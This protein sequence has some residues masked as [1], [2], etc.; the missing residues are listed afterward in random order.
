[1]SLIFI[2]ERF[3]VV[4]TI[5]Q[6]CNQSFIP[7][8]CASQSVG[9]ANQLFVS[10]VQTLLTAQ[11][12]ISPS[13]MWPEDYGPIA[14]KRGLD[15]YDFIVIGAGSA[16]ATVAS[17]LSEISDWKILLLEAGGDPPLEA[18]VPAMTFTLQNTRVDWKFRST[19]RKA[20][21]GLKDGCAFPRGKVLGGSSTINSMEY[22]RGIP[23]DFNHWADLGNTGWDFER[24]LPYFKKSENQQQPSLVA[25]QGGRYHSDKGPMKV[26][27]LGQI[28]DIESL[29]IAAANE[30]GIPF[31]PDINADQHY[32]CI[33]MQGTY[34]QGRRWSTAKAFLIPAKNRTNLHIIKHAFVEKILID[35]N[36]RAYGVRFSI[37]KCRKCKCRHKLTARAR[38]EVILSAGVVMSPILLK[39]SGIGPA[40]ELKNHNIPVKANLFGVGRNFLD[41]LYCF[42]LFKF[43]PVP[44]KP[45]DSL[46]YYY[47]FLTQN[48]G[49]YAQPTQL[50]AFLST[51]NNKTHPDIE[52]Y[53]YFFPPN[54][55]DFAF[56]IEL[57]NFLPEIKQRM[58][59][60]NK[61][62]SIAA[63]IPVLL[64]P[65]SSGFINLNGTCIRNKPAIYPH[66]LEHKDD[67]DRLVIAVKQ[68][69]EFTKTNAYQSFGGSFLP[70][71]IP[72]CDKL[73][74]SSDEFWRCYISYMSM[75]D[76]H[77]I[78]TCKMGPSTDRM[79]VVDPRLKVYKTLG[80]R[81]IDASM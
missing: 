47:Q 51:T 68:Q 77:G 9:A 36:N 44:T 49:P 79:A 21:R 13:N 75:S 60:T 42:L 5:M 2:D 48:S 55:P 35:R 18:D 67:L 34:A 14:L 12:S 41:H 23:D 66:Y 54:S 15:L 11:C 56:L 3:D 1:M 17:R 33:N 73:T 63:A 70:M 74:Y 71:P 8:D 24:V 59:D 78:G 57:M 80:L 61:E 16:G 28:G 46:D 62:F 27:Y 72:E 7:P 10:L 38:K 6:Y 25:Y 32:G 4:S 29:F 26:D 22:V 37:G 64:H 76:Y 58:Y 65:K 43:D 20:C 45:T 52:L 31:I 69:I 30:S 81:V 19:T 39:Y 40:N 53:I 50:A